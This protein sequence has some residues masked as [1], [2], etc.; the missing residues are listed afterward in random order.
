MDAQGF[1]ARDALML[2]G[3]GS[4]HQQI[5]A[6]AHSLEK[7]PSSSTKLNQLITLVVEF[8]GGNQ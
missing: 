5:S 1:A 7:V 6:S 8:Q 2:A 3:M 4:A